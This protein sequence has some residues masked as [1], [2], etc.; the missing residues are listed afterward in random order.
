MERKPTETVSVYKCYKYG[1]GGVGVEQILILFIVT[2]K[3]ERSLDIRM[4]LNII[5]EAFG[6]LLSHGICADG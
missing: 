1:E 5:I 3:I 4:S 6:Q 2:T